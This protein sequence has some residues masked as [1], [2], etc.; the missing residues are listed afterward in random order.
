MAGG[1]GYDLLPE[2]RPSPAL[3]QVEVRIDLIGTV[4]G[5]VQ[6]GMILQGGEGDP[7]RLRLLLDL[8]GAGNSVDIPKVSSPKELGDPEEGVAGGG[9]VAKA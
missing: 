6:L 4:D 1:L 3:D 5:E 9:A 8:P 2:H 7:Q